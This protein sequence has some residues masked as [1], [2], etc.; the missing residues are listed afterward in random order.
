MPEGSSLFCSPHF[1]S[2]DTVA[3]KKVE[4]YSR[5]KWATKNAA[6]SRKNKRIKNNDSLKTSRSRTAYFIR[7][8]F[9]SVNHVIVFLAVRHLLFSDAG[10]LY[11]WCWLFDFSLCARFQKCQ[12][13]DGLCMLFDRVTKCVCLCQDFFCSHLFGDSVSV[14]ISILVEGYFSCLDALYD[15]YTLTHALT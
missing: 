3:V 4:K 2:I 15:T 1:K 5:K 6:T 8:I 12:R 14:L 11:W 10:L 7:A 13:A 9:S